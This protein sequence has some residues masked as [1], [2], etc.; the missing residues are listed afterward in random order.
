MISTQLWLRYLAIGVGVFILI[1]LPFEDTSEQS[2]IIIALIISVLL[3]TQWLIN[4]PVE[5]SKQLLIHSIVGCL[6]GA[7]TIFI[8]ILLIAFKSGLHNHG[9]AEYSKDQIINIFWL[10]PYFVISGFL[11]GLSSAIWR[12]Q[13]TK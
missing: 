12:L 2:A 8:T 4:L 7:A 3:A 11:L 1:W 5:H 9:F 10:S 6:A 13:K